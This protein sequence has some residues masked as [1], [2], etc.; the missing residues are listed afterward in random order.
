MTSVATGARATA[1]RDITIVVA[2]VTRGMEKKKDGDRH[3]AKDKD[4]GGDAKRD[5]CIASAVV[6]A[7]ASPWP[8]STRTT[9]CLTA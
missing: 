1:A 4:K 9:D 5:A 7:M 8:P 3:D 6:P 2:T